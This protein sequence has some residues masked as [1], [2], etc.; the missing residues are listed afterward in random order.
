MTLKDGINKQTTAGG[1]LLQDYPDDLIINRPDLKS[2][3]LI[4][5]EG[6][7]TLL[8]WGFWFYLWL[9][10]ISV[11]AWLLGFQILYSHIMAL[12]GLDEFLVQFN[13]FSIGIFAASGILALWSFYNL[14]RYG[15]YNRRNKIYT[16]DMH[17]LAA[18]LSLSAGELTKI[19]Q[20]KT[21]HFSFDEEGDIQTIATPADRFSVAEQPKFIC[22][23]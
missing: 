10:L 2:R 18:H 7:L 3:P 15:A 14:K 4:L 19:Q 9:P 13:I 12:G 21:L 5:G 16:T 17:G 1:D 6:I 22:T 11:V 8:F 23:P 20:A